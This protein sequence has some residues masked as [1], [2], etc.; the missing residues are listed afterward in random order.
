M[1]N[2]DALFAPASIALLGAGGGPGSVGEVVAG[3]LLAGGFAGPLMLVDPKGLPVLG[4]EVFASV[5]GLPAAPDLAVIATPARVVAG[6]IAELGARGCRAAVVI[7]AGFEGD[8][9]AGAARRAAVLDAARPHGLRV[10]G[11]NCLGLLSPGAGVNASFA[12]S[13]PQAGPVALVAQS[14]AVAAAALDWAPA[15]GLGFSHVITL[16]DSLDVDAGDVIDHLADDPATQVILVYLEALS[17]ARRFMAAARRATLAKPVLL[18]KGGRSAA[19]ARAAFS[20]TRALAGAHAV[21]SAAFRR[22]GVMQLDG[23]DDL[24]ETALAV[25]AARGTAPANLTIVTNGGG[26]GVLATDALE[27]AGGRLTA[28][29]PQTRAALQ[30]V[31]PASASSGNPV[32][33]LGDA[34]PALHGAALDVVLAAP[35]VEAALAIHCPTAVTDS[36][37]A[38]AAVAAAARRGAKP[39]LAAWLGEMSVAAGRRRLHGAGVPAFAT[40]E[41]AVRAFARLEP[42]G[43][44]RAPRAEPSGPPTAPA[45]LARAQGVVARALAAGRR[46]LDPL[47]TQEVLDAYG[48]PVIRSRLVQTPPEAGRVAAAIGG[49]VALKIVSRQVSHKSDVGGVQLGLEG[50]AA[51]IAAAQT[52]ADRLH[53]LRPDA[54]L[55]GFLVQAMADRPRAWEVLAGLVRDPTFGPVVVVGHGGVAV[56]VLADRAL[57]LAPLG[58]EDAR[59]AIARTQVARLLAGYRD[60]PG[61]DLDALATTLVALGRLAVDLPEV[62]ELDLNPLLCDAEGVIAVD[63]RIAIGP[64]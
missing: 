38:A 53:T 55:D 29:S 14:G 43:R 32:D 25:C 3:N 40:A 20:H 13:R 19:G 42:L 10:V 57:A 41:A 11:P 61:A 15:H 1:S 50:A 8:D 36:D 56:E 17:D 46:S 49:P 5:A 59:D 30:A 22:A 51:T 12:R 31:L 9:E 48:I 28:L 21:Y 58:L 4:R 47:E 44:L 33:I 23:L 35:E 2:L 64:A 54:V 16:G 39:V 24:L 26:A 6:A 60:R 45:D 18:L 27:R 34:P 63:A 37:E 7:T 62:A 52:M